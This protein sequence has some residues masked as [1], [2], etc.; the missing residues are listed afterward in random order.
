M[1]EKMTGN[2]YHTTMVCV[3]SYQ[4]D[5]LKGRLINPSRDGAIPFD[6][7]MQFFLCMEDLLDEMRFPQS[8]EEKRKFFAEDGTAVVS[9][10]VGGQTGAQAT[11]AV[12]ILFRQNASWQGSIIW[13][14]EKQEESFRSALELAL[15]MHSALTASRSI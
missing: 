5:V 14:E 9:R 15:L 4:N 11:F 7:L 1:Q 3:D 8:F 12:R 10:T 6:S 2:K 13:T